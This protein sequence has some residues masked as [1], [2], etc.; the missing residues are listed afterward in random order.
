MTRRVFEKLCIG[1]APEKGRVQ[2]MAS[3]SFSFSNTHSIEY[4]LRYVTQVRLWCTQVFPPSLQH[5]RATLARVRAWQ[6]PLTERSEL[7]GMKNFAQK[8]FALIFW[9]LTLSIRTL[10]ADTVFVDPRFRNS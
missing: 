10:I 2:G 6:R 1:L 8:K 5:C 4:S 9:P 7:F 3:P